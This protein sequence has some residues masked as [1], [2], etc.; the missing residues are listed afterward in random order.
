MSYSKYQSI[1]MPII[2]EVYEE[3]G[4]YSLPLKE[5]VQKVY[6]KIENL[7]NFTYD[8]RFMRDFIYENLK[9]LIEANDPN[10]V[11]IIDN[12][13]Q[14]CSSYQEYFKSLK[15]LPSLTQEEREDLALKAFNGDSEAKKMLI[16]ANL[17][18]VFNIVRYYNN[19]GVEVQEL[20]QEGNLALIKA[21]NRFDPTKGYRFSSYATKFIRYHL[22]N[23]LRNINNS[24]NLAP[25]KSY[26]TAL[27]TKIDP[28]LSIEETYEQKEMRRTVKEVIA[29]VDLN[30][31]EEKALIKDESI[32][33]RQL[34]RNLGMSAERI[35]QKKSTALRKLRTDSLTEQLALYTSNPESALT[36][37]ANFQI[38]YA[39]D[40]RAM[41]ISNVNLED[42][43][44]LITE[45]NK[46]Q[47]L[48]TYFSE[49]NYTEKEINTAISYLE[50]S[51]Q[52]IIRIK[53]FLNKDKNGLM[54]LTS[55]QI[56]LLYNKIIPKLIQ[57]LE[58]IYPKTVPIRKR[59]W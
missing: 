47:S 36:N 37:L 46:Y 23:Y 58:T 20:I 44:A 2:N 48:Y 41:Q 29:K 42:Y 14:T 3:Y 24:L 43:Q 25:R 53:Y 4:P 49:Y 34:G 50:P 5:Y 27:Q 22:I 18:L 51:Y 12:D 8:K 56:R 16:T 15:E 28:S 57:I 17:K 30:P 54:P 10:Y 11:F 6:E 55:K 1:I 59:K 45:I 52:E 26:E 40:H 35:R 9:M 38:I 39:L 33:L 21:V 32:S 31:Q 7:A 19:C 13:Y